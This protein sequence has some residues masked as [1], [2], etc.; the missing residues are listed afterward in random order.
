MDKDIKHFY[1]FWLPT[2]PTEK[3]YQFTFH[4]ESELPKTQ[5]IPISLYKNEHDTTY[6]LRLMEGDSE[7]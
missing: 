6:F 3:L 5:D 2:F 4:L 7:R 1:I